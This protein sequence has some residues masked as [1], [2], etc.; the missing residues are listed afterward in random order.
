MIRNATAK[1]DWIS[2]FN[3]AHNQAIKGEAD[4]KYASPR[5]SA[6]RHMCVTCFA[7]F[8]SP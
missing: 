1:W 3:L 5:A 6:A 2:R 7:A 8:L 4:H